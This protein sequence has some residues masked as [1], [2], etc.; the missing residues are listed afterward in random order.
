MRRLL[1][2]SVIILSAC[3]S[4][5]VPP[6]NEEISRLVLFT[7]DM[8]EE[9]KVGPV[10][11]DLGME[12]L[13]LLRFIPL[14]NY[15][16][17]GF[18]IFD[19]SRIWISY[20]TGDDH[21]VGLQGGQTLEELDFSNGNRYT[22]N[23]M[24]ETLTGAGPYMTLINLQPVSVFPFFRLNVIEYD[25]LFFTP[26]TDVESQIE[27]DRPPTDIDFVSGVDILPDFGMDRV[28]FLCRRNFFPNEFYEIRYDAGAFAPGLFNPVDVR[29]G[30]PTVFFPDQPTQCFYY[31]YEPLGV[32]GTS[33]AQYRYDGGWRTLRWDTT[34]LGAPMQLNI[35]DKIEALL[36]NGQ[37]FCVDDDTAYVYDLDGVLHYEI[38]LGD[39]RFV[40]EVWDGDKYKMIFVLPY[41]VDYGDNTGFVF[42]VY[43]IDT[44]DLGKLAKD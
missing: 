37:L 18:L 14:K 13:S 43:S 10:D 24:A 23:Y 26:S 22:L 36:T 19:D 27:T 40:Y 17:E 12:Q 11:L 25:H 3:L 20:V 35:P 16:R 21:V 28:Y 8:E 41:Y 32:E 31:H 7:S 38:K 1:V 39:M 44:E 42:K 5:Y 30:F 9:A 34:M 6:F 4:C 29:I 15:Y 33:I 2:L